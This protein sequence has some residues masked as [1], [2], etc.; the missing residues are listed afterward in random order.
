M[1]DVRCSSPEGRHWGRAPR[2]RARPA[3]A[4][5]ARKR[6]SEDLQAESAKTNPAYIRQLMA[7][8]KSAD[9]LAGTQGQADPEL[10]RG[11]D[12]ITMLDVYRA[13]EGDKTRLHFVLTGGAVRSHSGQRGLPQIRLRRPAPPSVLTGWIFPGHRLAE[14]PVSL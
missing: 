1:R 13:V 5:K 10:T 7:A 14:S 4:G 3:K 6:K 12:E 2:R 8:L 9:I 11:S